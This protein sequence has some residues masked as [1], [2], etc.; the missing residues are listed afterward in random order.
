[1]A[2][3]DGAT[4]EQHPYGPG[5]HAPL[6]NEREMPGCYPVKGNVRT[7]GSRLYHRPD[8]RSYR[9][10]IAEVWFDS[11]SAAEAAGFVLAPTHPKGSTGEEFEPG[12]SGHGCSE[13]EVMANRAA[14]GGAAV[15]GAGVAGAGVVL[16][17]AA[18][19]EALHP[20]GIGSH[21]PL[22]DEREMP[23]CYPVKGNVRTDGSRLYHR[24]DSRSYR[25]T[26]AEVWFDSPS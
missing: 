11:P 15:A 21:A 3:N 24:P 26:I 18:V 2:D 20:F 6:E 10:T 7:D 5:S 12:G 22:A 23:G 17:G 4:D 14:A 13:A 1:M 8:S 19:D 9:A 25:A 16:G